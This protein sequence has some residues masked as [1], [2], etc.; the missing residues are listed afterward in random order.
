MNRISA[1]TPGAWLIG[2]L[3]LLMFQPGLAQNP[4]GEVISLSGAPELIRQSTVLAV[5]IGDAVFDS[6]TLRTDNNARL[7][8]EMLDGSRLSID[9]DSRVS[10][11]DYL[12]AG[13]PSATL[14]VFRGRLRSVVSDTFS[15]RRNAF[16]IRTSTAVVG[17]Q[18][19]DFLVEAFAASTRITVYRGLV[20]VSNADPAVRGSQQ[21]TSRQTVL[22]RRGEPPPVPTTLGRAGV[23]GGVADTIGSGGETDRLYGDAPV[24][25][26]SEG[27]TGGA[28]GTPPSVPRLV[29][30]DNPN[31]PR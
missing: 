7:D 8:I 17:V 30:P 31:L 2:L 22:V 1:R 6:D 11:E 14:G 27:V 9:R 23:V 15:R 18:G 19:T 25:P 24:V 20:E 16:R 21:L 29:V 5:A 4:V 13:Q 26:G 28:L 3:C 12:P 10:I